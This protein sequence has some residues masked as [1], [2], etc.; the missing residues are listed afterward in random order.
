MQLLLARI[1]RTAIGI[2]AVLMLVLPASAEPSFRGTV[3][4]AKIM[5]NLKMNG[6]TRAKVSRI[7]ST[8]AAEL[9]SVLNKYKINPRG[10]LDFDTM[11]KAS[12]ELEAV[13]RKEREALRNV[14]SPEQFQQYEII[15][16]QT[17]RRVRR[18][19]K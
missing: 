16:S 4:D 2:L 8:S 17:S 11:M 9:Q 6:Q 10:K 3:F 19:M 18:A 14:L 5:Q 13:Q 15:T 7:V 12:S 1:C